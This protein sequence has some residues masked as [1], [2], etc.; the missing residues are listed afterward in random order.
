[1][2]DLR[3]KDF[4]N[5]DMLKNTLAKQDIQGSIN[6][7]LSNLPQKLDTEEDIDNLHIRHSQLDLNQD[8]ADSI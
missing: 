2:S 6:S 4:S 3:F 8:N 7:I 5:I 1:M